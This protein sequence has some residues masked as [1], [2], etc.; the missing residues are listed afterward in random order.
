MEE[1]LTTGEEIVIESDSKMESYFSSDAY[2]D[3]YNTIKQYPLLSLE[4][5]IK[6]ALLAQNGDVKAKEKLINS[7]LRLVVA[8]A[9]RY[10]NRVTHM[11]ILDI[12]QEGCLGLIKSIET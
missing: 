4:E 6:L 12:I 3:F 11:Q 7:N 1:V 10:K 8:V 2:R 5:N 9:H